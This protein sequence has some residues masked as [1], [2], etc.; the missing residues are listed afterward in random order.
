LLS[1][2]RTSLTALAAALALG[3]AAARAAGEGEGATPAGAPAEP[4]SPPAGAPR[5]PRAADDLGEEIAVVAPSRLPRR[6]GPGDGVNVETVDREELRR[7]AARSVQDALQQVPGVALAD[8]QGNPFQ[9]DLSMRG[10]VASPVTGLSQGLSVFLDGVRVNEPGVEEVNFDLLPLSDLER[11]EVIRGPHAIFGRNT[12]G[13][14]IQLVTLRGAARPEADAEV[15]AGSFAAQRARARASGPL[16]PLDALVSVAEATEKGWRVDQASRTVRAFGKLGYARGDTDVAL[17]YQWTED[18]LA[19]PGPLP[20]SMLEQDRTQ[21]YTAG[22]FFQP[23]LSFATLNVRQG[24][25]DRL[26]LAVNAYARA[27]DAEQFNA[28]FTAPDTRMFNRTRSVGGTIQLEHDGAWG[29]VRSHAVAGAEATHNAIE[30]KVHEEPNA[31]VGTGENDRPLP[32]LVGDLSDAQVALGAF[33]QAQVIARGGPVSGLG[34]TA[35]VRYDRIS[36]DIVDTSPP[37]PGCASGTAEYARW[38]PAAGISWTFSPRASASASW[39]AGFR[40]PAFLELTCADPDAPC[41]GLQAGVAPDATLT[42]LRPVTS[43]SFEAGI[44]A[45]P[46]DGLVASANAFRI[47]LHDDIYSV[48]GSTPTSLYFKNV[49]ST[50]RTGLEATVRAERGPVTAVLGY[51]YTRATFESDATL[52]TPRTASGFQEVH[53]GDR[54]PMIPEHQLDAEGR[55]RPWRWL[56]VSAGVHWVGAQVYRGDEANEGPLLPAYATVRAGV[57]ARW[58]RWSAAVHAANLLDSRY[59]TFG[60]YAVNGRSGVGVEPFLTPGTPLRV[61]ANLR[62]ALD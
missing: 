34:A 44:A 58:G 36:H 25:S 17:S 51:A 54:L 60:T 1:L 18:R 32:Q 61:F 6:R 62:W 7:S 27:L 39:S 46:L 47:D 43:Q 59:E 57:E 3:A 21:N 26:A 49:G 45:E 53:P 33:L 41:I 9:Q 4:A 30:V 55:V 38:V 35:A 5:A 22:D 19:E 11:V 24:L 10:L 20:L 40:A 8:E 50:R 13:G 52:A 15:G 56:E 12:L 48:P 31:Q 42:H 28:G 29:P 37:C 2:A 16:G 23:T 14:A